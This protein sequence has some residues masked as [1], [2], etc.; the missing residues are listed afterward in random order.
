MII[1][2][3]ENI[4][5]EYGGPA[6]SL[7][8]FLFSVEKELNIFSRIYSIKI[9]ENEENEFIQRYGLDWVN[10]ELTGPK[11]FMY[12]KSLQIA[13]KKKLSDDNII[14]SNNLWNYP[15]FLSAKLARKHSIPHIISIRGTLYPW[16]LKQGKWRK[17]LAWHLFQKKALQQANVLHVTCV[18]ELN[19]VRSLGIKTPVA[20]IPHGINYNDYQNLPNKRKALGHL[21]LKSEKKYLLFMSR[22]HKKK[23]LDLLLSIWPNIIK[24][25]PDWCLL[26][27]GPDYSDYTKKIEELISKFN[28]ADNIKS[29]G[30][31]TGDKK[32]SA[33]SVASLFVLPS[34][35]ENFGVVIGEALAS[36]LPTITTTGT[37]WPE[38]IDYNCGRYI[39]LSARNLESAI[40]DLLVCNDNELAFMSL[41]AKALIKEKYSWTIQAQ[42]FSKVFN[43][44]HKGQV[45][46]TVIKL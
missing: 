20:L 11:K 21:N 14:F 7:P 25:H 2:I 38:I 9:S 12:S 35:S 30:M 36:G 10:C 8:N 16:S 43:F 33:F 45:D 6:N 17:K 32:Y 41:A 39:E 15:A 1:S 19:A 40:N 24:K 23:G 5:N 29:L 44:I 3:I 28:I 26:V 4:S 18:D 34:F 42:R 31:L 27:V 13:I 22:L 37:P 46:P